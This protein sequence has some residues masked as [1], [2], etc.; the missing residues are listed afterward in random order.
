VIPEIEETYIVYWFPPDG[1]RSRNFKDEAKA[2]R[3]ATQDDEVSS[4]NPILV[5]RVREI[6]TTETIL[7]GGLL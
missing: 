4:W 5:H 1:D 6:T 2:R 7:L 3:L